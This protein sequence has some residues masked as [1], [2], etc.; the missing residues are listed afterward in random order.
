M[1][2]S[3]AE[4]RK[5]RAT[6]AV[7]RSLTLAP[8]AYP[9]ASASRKKPMVGRRHHDGAAHMGHQPAQRDDLGAQRAEAFNENDQVEQVS[10][11]GRVFK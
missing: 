10:G 11:H 5:L 1:P 7:K 4:I 8:D 2:A 9:R 3:S 6:T